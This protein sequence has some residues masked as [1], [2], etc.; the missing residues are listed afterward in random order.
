MYSFIA[1]TQ[2]SLSRWPS[3]LAY[4]LSVGVGTKVGVGGRVGSGEGTGT[5]V[6]VTTGMAVGF[7][8]STV[9]SVFPKLL[10]NMS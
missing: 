10:A 9:G 3:P 4:G 5:M 6:G 1:D 7:I 2:F 8:A